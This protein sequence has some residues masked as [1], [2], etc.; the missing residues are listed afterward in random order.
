MLISNRF[1]PNR[2]GLDLSTSFQLLQDAPRIKG[3]GKRKAEKA[4]LDLGKGLFWK[5][6][7]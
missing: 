1:I 3:K 6:F 4:D 5:R 7:C 2:E